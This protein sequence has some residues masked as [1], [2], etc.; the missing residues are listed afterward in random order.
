MKKQL[1]VFAAVI[2]SLVTLFASCTKPQTTW[3]TNLDEAKTAASKQKKDLLIAFTGSDWNDPSKALI[4]DVFTKDFFK[5]E[6]GNSCSQRSTSCRTKPRWTSGARGEL[7]GRD[8]LRSP[9][10]TLVRVRNPDGDVYA[11]ASV[12]EDTKTLDAVVKY[13]DTFK[14]ARKKL[15]DL[16]KRSAR[17]RAPTRRRQSTSSSRP[18]SLRSANSTPISSAR[19]PTSTR[20]ERAGLKGKYQLQ[21]AYLDAVALY[22]EK[23]LTEAGDCFIK[24]AEGTTLS[25]AQSTGSLVHGRVHVR[26]VRY[27]RERKSSGMA[28]KSHRRR[29]HETPGA[30][31]IKQTIEQIKKAPPKALAGNASN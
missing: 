30:E 24:L 19:F 3:I 15:V 16:K 14:D 6:S 13:L 29:P 2:V 1:P 22:Q 17:Q 12:A 27:G 23:K 31:Q 5:K 7:Q 21:V 18:F 20:T 11:T 25:A 9:G 4:K 8:D 10:V 28:R 26:H